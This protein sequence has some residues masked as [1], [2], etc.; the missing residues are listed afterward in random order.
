MVPAEVERETEG[1]G[2]AMGQDSQEA[3]EVIGGAV[4]P[5]P[6]GAFSLS[7]SYPL[8]ILEI[9]RDGVRVRLRWRWSTAIVSWV[10]RTTRLAE[11]FDGEWRASWGAIDRV[12]VGPSSIVIYRGSGHPSRFVPAP[13]GKTPRRAVVARLEAEFV[14]HDV[15]VERKRITVGHGL[16]MRRNSR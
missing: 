1:R 5:G 12:L 10:G 8:V 9:A 16:Q 2:T 4:I 11:D 7:A 3:F 14:A 6:P 15:T 13:F